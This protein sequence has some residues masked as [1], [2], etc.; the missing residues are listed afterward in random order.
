[1]SYFCIV[2]MN[3]LLSQYGFWG[4]WISDREQTIHQNPTSIYSGTV[5]NHSQI[6]NFFNVRKYVHKTPMS[7]FPIWSVNDQQW[8]GNPSGWEGYFDKLWTLS[9]IAALYK[10]L[11][12]TA[13][14]KVTE[15]CHLLSGAYITVIMIFLWTVYIMIYIVLWNKTIKLNWNY[16][17]I[18]VFKYI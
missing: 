10:Y 1:M 8:S 18:S 2:S 9:A 3:A 16:K 13:L 6:P 7:E 11:G 12:Q 5:R 4:G 15:N 17:W 14:E